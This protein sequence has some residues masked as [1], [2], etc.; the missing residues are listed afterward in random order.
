MTIDTG[1][2]VRDFRGFKSAG[3][4]FDLI[5]PINVIVGKNNIG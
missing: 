5:K 4:G 3:A 2:W 1:F